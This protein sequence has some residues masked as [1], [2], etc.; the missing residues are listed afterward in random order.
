MYSNAIWS[1]I[2]RF[3]VNNV[4]SVNFV[5]LDIPMG[6]L[7]WMHPEGCT[8]H[9]GG[10][11]LSPIRLK[12][13]KLLIIYIYVTGPPGALSFDVKPEKV[14][15]T[16]VSSELPLGHLLHNFPVVSS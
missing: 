9:W 2:N 12:P 7:H 6:Q 3:V 5:N 10:K 13:F 8:S 11:P 1:V 14:T 16:A 4:K 15:T